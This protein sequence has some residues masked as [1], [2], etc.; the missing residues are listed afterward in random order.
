MTTVIILY[1]KKQLSS[2]KF[3]RV[4]VEVH[5]ITGPEGQRGGVEV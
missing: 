5:H 1:E 4:K 2:M 3:Y